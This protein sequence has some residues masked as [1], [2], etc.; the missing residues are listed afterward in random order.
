MLL[1]MQTTNTSDLV[2]ATFEA[3]AN[4]SADAN[5]SPVC[6]GCGWLEPDHGDAL[7]ELRALPVRRPAGRVTR[8]TPKRL[9]S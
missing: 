1:R 2:S 9:A 7:G 3:C 4:Y 5:G 8:T 6:A